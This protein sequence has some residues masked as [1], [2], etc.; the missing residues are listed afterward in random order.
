MDG[1]IDIFK[2]IKFPTIFF[3]DSSCIS[4]RRWLTLSGSHL[5]SVF[6]QMGQLSSRKGSSLE[7]VCFSYKNLI[8]L[9][10]DESVQNKIRLAFLLF[11]AQQ[12]NTFL[13]LLLQSEQPMMHIAHPD[14]S[15][16]VYFSEHRQTFNQVK[17]K[18]VK[19]SL[20]TWWNLTWSWPASQA[21]RER[22]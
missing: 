4:K 16:P 21:S 19:N 20:A 6:A 14:V 17:W 9:L 10:C 7:S 2:K 18:S 1:E 12:T 11:L 3:M 22:T 8:E 5:G 13:T 15:R